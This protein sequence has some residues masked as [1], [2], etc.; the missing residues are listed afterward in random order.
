M[1]YLFY[2]SVICIAILCQVPRVF[3]VSD[4]PRN[5]HYN[6]PINEAVVTS[7]YKIPSQ[8]DALEKVHWVTPEQN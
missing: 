5:P 3:S 8:W 1:L 2:S 6:V 4:N 7:P